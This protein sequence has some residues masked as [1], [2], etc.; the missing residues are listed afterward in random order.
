MRLRHVWLVLLGISAGCYR[1][2]PV[3]PAAARPE[4]ELRVR[5]TDAAA[6]RLVRDLG[7]YTTEL[8]GTFKRESAD[9]VSVS[10]SIARD[11]R[12]ATLENARQALFLAPAEIVELR[13]REFSRSRTALVAAG[14]LVGFA[15]LVATVTQLG[16]PN[17]PAGDDGPPPP[18]PIVSP[19]PSPF[20][21]S[22]HV[23]RFRVPVF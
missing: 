17:P 19:K 18:P 10:V 12:G 7:T 15:A 2:V 11:Y 16:D 14:S 20:G 9:S 21:L 3:A 8:D 1:Y 23:L 5:V 22:P 4:E 13:R 6:V